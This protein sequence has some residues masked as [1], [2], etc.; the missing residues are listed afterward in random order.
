V[1]GHPIM[2]GDFELLA[3]HAGDDDVALS[4]ASTWTAS[5]LRRHAAKLAQSLPAAAEG[6]EALVLCADRYCFAVSALAAWQAGYCIALPPNAQPQT[7]RELMSDARLQLLLHDGAW[8]EGVDVRATV[9]D[10][11]PASR[12]LPERLLFRGDQRLATVYTSGS[13]GDRRPHPKAAHQLLGEARVLAQT[14]GVG[15]GDRVLATVPAQH[16]YGLLVGV[17][18]P[19]CSGAAIVLGTPLHAE[20]VAARVRESSATVLASVPAHLRGLAALD[21][22]ALGGVRLIVS[23]G[24]PLEAD[25]AAA[26]ERF[27]ARLAELLGSTETGGIALRVPPEE[28]WRPL[29]GVS[30][31]TGAENQLLLDSPFLDAQAARPYDG[32][33]KIASKRVS[34]S[35]M[36]QRLRAIDGVHDAAALAVPVDGGRGHEVWAAVVAPSLAVDDVRK[37]LLQWFDPVVL[38]RR[39]RFVAALPREATGKLPRSRL[40]ALFDGSTGAERTMQGGFHLKSRSTRDDAGLER[41]EVIFD[42]PADLP[43]LKGHFDGYPILAGVVILNNIVLAESKLA[44]P[45]LPGLRQL[46]RL[47]FRRPIHPDETVTLR[48]ERKTGEASIDFQAFSN[49]H[50]CNSGTLVFGDAS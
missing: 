21:T 50:P 29:P 3:R 45:D 47:K 16:I 42:V 27:G 41:R 14:L 17:L 46:V 22:A 1:V 48:L 43:F 4:G 44:W 35:E 38:P 28:W 18:V 19:L 20:A 24:A 11:T 2:S 9:A 49:G 33:V 7:V 26:L 23:S 30:V 13:T 34:L 36:E 40:S 5:D 15:P 10:P 32:V 25:T 31:A 37:Q 8:G 12:P 39:L 6:A